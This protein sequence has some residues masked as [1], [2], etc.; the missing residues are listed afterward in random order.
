M[1]FP[2]LLYL[3]L[4]YLLLNA[5]DSHKSRR[6]LGGPLSQLYVG[7]FAFASSGLPTVFLGLHVSTWET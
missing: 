1:C 2:P 4:I 7:Q 5:D 6:Y 3:R